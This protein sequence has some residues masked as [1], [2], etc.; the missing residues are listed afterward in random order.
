VLGAHP[1]VI[2][3]GELDWLM[4]HIMLPPL[5]P[6]PESVPGLDGTKLAEVAATYRA[7]LTR[8]FPSAPE[9]RY[10]TDKRPDNL[11]L[12]GLIKSLF[13][14][15]RIVLTVRD[16]MDTG[17]SIY[18]QH[19]NPGR[20][21]YATDLSATGH[22][23][24]QMRRLAAHWKARW[25]EDVVEIDYDQLVQAPRPCI[26]RLLSFLGLPWDERCLEFHRHIGVVRTASFRQVRQPFHARSSGR[27]RRYAPHLAPLAQALREG[28]YEVA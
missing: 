22:H 15:A 27:W 24:G 14:A 5:A 3:G 4:R 20:V 17:L 12:V 10:V 16:P 13:P 21:P 19:L 9:M 28:G 8:L 18:S 26:K 25:P 2:A 6:Y 23:L 1:A 7:H 11:L